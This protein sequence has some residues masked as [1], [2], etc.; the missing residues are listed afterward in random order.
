MAGF[1]KK[2]IGKKGKD[3]K[4]QGDAGS[5]T[6]HE[7]S[8]DVHEYDDESASLDSNRNASVEASQVVDAQTS[9]FQAINTQTGDTVNIPTLDEADLKFAMDQPEVAKELDPLDKITHLIQS[10]LAAAKISKDKN[11]TLEMLL[12]ITNKL[13]RPDFDEDFDV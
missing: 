8:V 13:Q 12:E 11:E 7:V 2:L 10:E 4:P 5:W 1:F 9:D 6:E 3:S